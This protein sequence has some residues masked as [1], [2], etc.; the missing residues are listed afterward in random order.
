ML[1]ESTGGPRIVKHE[2]L[3]SLRE[4]NNAFSPRRL[5]WRLSNNLVIFLL[6]WS[7]P[8]PESPKIM[9]TV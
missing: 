5:E 1:R 6:L 9:S 7:L 3:F 8:V 4:R 2:V